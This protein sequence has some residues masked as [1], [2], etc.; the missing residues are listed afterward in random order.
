MGDCSTANVNQI[1]FTELSAQYTGQQG[2]DGNE[3]P[4][5]I[6]NDG[7]PWS[8]TIPNAPPGNYILRDEVSLLYYKCCIGRLIRCIVDRSPF[9][10]LQSWVP[11]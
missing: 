1:Q 11:A 2:Y 7:Q 6:L 4:V 9:F 10:E 8:I 3:W 5:K